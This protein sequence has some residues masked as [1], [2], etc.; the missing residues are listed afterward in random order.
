MK[1]SQQYKFYSFL[2]TRFYT[3]N[4]LFNHLCVF[5]FFFNVVLYWAFSLL[6]KEILTNEWQSESLPLSY[7]R[8]KYHWK[9]VS[10]RCLRLFAG[11]RKKMYTVVTVQIPHGVVMLALSIQYFNL[12]FWLLSKTYCLNVKT[13]H[14]PKTYRTE[15]TVSQNRTHA[16]NNA[17]I[18]FLC[19]ICDFYL[20]YTLVLYSLIMICIFTLFIFYLSWSLCVVSFRGKNTNVYFISR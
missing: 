2:L 16:G 8:F 5:L 20:Y 3:N 1:V 17:C 18:I 13:C 19:A 7:C 4:W 6:S 10:L 15:Q 11:R 9:L 12:W 14:F